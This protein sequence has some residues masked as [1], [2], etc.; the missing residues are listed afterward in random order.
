MGGLG[1]NLTF[2]VVQIARAAPAVGQHRPTEHTAMIEQ[3]VQAQDGLGVVGNVEGSLADRAIAVQRCGR[4]GPDRRTG[5][6]RL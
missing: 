6:L 1:D 4:S 5:N 2:Q 3:I